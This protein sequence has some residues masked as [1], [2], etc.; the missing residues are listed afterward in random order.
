MTRKAY[1]VSVDHTGISEDRND[2]YVIIAS[3]EE[4]ATELGRLEALADYPGHEVLEVRAYE[5][6]TDTTRVLG[7]L[8]PEDER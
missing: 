1:T 6:S 8:V 7:R 2:L 5:L 3:S 4:R